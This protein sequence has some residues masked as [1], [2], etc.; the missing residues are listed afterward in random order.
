[1]SPLEFGAP[2]DFSQ[3]MLRLPEGSHPLYETDDV[4]EHLTH[5]GERLTELSILGVLDQESLG[6][7][8]LE[9]RTIPIELEDLYFLESISFKRSLS[10]ITMAEH[11]YIERGSVWGDYYLQD[12]EDHGWWEIYQMKPDLEILN[13]KLICIMYNKYI[14]SAG[15]PPQ[16]SRLD[17]DNWDIEIGVLK[18]SELILLT[19]LL[20]RNKQS[21]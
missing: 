15:F 9:E 16:R 8:P 2:R 5:F 12:D 19:Q 17:K 14:G 3:A 18:D 10:L 20:D 1:M 7:L 6:N 21:N 11:E 4:I 13:H